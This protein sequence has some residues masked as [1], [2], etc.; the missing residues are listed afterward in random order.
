MRDYD[1]HQFDIKDSGEREQYDS[2]MVRDIE[3]DKV[4][5]TNLLHG[6]MLVRWAEHLT[7]AKDKYPDI[8]PG[9]PNWTLAEGSEEYQRYRRSAFR[10]LIQWLLG[11]RDEDHAAA[12]MF[13]LNGAEYV[14][15]KMNKSAGTAFAPTEPINDPDEDLYLHHGGCHCNDVKDHK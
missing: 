1:Q 5:L 11:M 7:Q 14:L 8:E 4:D 10:H 6:P 15:D 12:V 3:A 9:M 2:G 13:N